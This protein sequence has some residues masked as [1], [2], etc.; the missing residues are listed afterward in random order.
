MSI[1]F[2]LKGGLALLLLALFFT[3]CQPEENVTLPVDELAEP[4][5]NYSAEVALAWNQLILDI[6]RYADGYRP[7]V[8][9]RAMG[10][11]GLAAYEAVVPG[12]TNYRSLA[13]RFAGFNPPTVQAGQRYYWPAALNEAYV[14]SVG[15]F[16]PH[17]A[18][19]WK[20]RVH[21]LEYRFKSRFANELAGQGEAYE[22]SKAF[23]REVAEAVFA[24]STT[25]AVGHE[26]F[27]RNN[28]PG[29]QPN[30]TQ[31]PGLWLPTPPEYRPALLPYW[32][33]VRP[34]AARPDRML[35]LPPVAYSEKK[36]DQFYEEAME[37]FNTT[38]KLSD[39][40]RWVAIFWSDDVPQLTFTPAARW[41]AIANQVVD[42]QK[43][44][45]AKAVTMYAQ[46]AMALADAGISCWRSKYHYNI[47]RPVSYIRRV[48]SP[49]WATPTAV[50]SP[51]FPAYP[52]GH[53]T[54]GAA[55]AAILT[56]HFGDKYTMTDRCHEG[57]TD[58]DG[59]P[60]TFTSFRQMAEENAISR[61]YL[62]VHYRMDCVEG[63]RLGYE[64]G[65]DVLA[66]PWQK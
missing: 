16:F 58:F 60:R 12:M 49:N 63:L 3:A 14:T 50:T 47:E 35:A 64:R 19:Q 30:P 37:V 25:D 28:M 56:A 17:I 34:F 65:N 61:I 59:R 24:W 27:L 55:A 7:P 13:P 5:E 21:D 48:V 53:S 1:N 9:A 54:F 41:I 44:D 22:R 57:R 45:L 42:A 4:T 62:G 29:Y 38:R 51:P 2:T 11:I 52:S 66:L 46:L 40:Q 32:G 15:R 10:Y 6:E 43:P 20:E 23:G 36:G 31:Q 8:S 33:D 26:G 39:E 18:P